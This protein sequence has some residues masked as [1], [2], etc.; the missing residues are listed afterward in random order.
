MQCV[1]EKNNHINSEHQLKCTYCEVVVNTDRQLK[2]HTDHHHKV[3]TA[4]VDDGAL[5]EDDPSNLKQ[6]DVENTKRG[7]P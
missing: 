6:N 1:K 5:I 7:A 4:Q 3:T 2:E